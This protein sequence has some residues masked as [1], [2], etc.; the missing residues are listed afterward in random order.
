MIENTF[1]M[2]I[3]P[4]NEH[5]RL[6]AL[7]RYKIMGTPA[8]ASFDGI[9]KLA[10]QFFN[11]PIALL[12]LVMQNR[13]ISKQISAWAPQRKRIEGKVCVVWLFWTRK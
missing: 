12:S 6:N 5:D 9:A 8:E 4:E 7:R 3:M 2:D 1:G 10:S 13:S 11:A